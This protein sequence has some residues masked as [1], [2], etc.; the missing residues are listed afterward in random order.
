MKFFD[1]LEAVKFH[2]HIN[3]CND[4]EIFSLISYMF[5]FFHVAQY[6]SFVTFYIKLPIFQKA[7]RV[8]WDPCYTPGIVFG[9]HNADDQGPTVFLYNSHCSL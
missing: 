3:C 8:Y 2:V 7:Y 4:A 6:T 1:C 9:Y 5:E